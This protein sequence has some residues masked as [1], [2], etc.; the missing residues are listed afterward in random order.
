CP[1]I[2]AHNPAV[3]V[4]LRCHPHVTG[5]CAW[6]CK[7]VRKSAR[8]PVVHPVSSY[9]LC[10]PPQFGS[11]AWTA[12]GATGAEHEASPVIDH[13]RIKGAGA[14]EEAVHLETE[15]PTREIAAAW[16]PVASDGEQL[17]LRDDRVQALLSCSSEGLCLRLL[18]VDERRLVVVVGGIE[19]VPADP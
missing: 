3:P 17:D 5:E 4:P 12:Y 7:S 11:P 16:M 15:L 1:D 19:Q 18:L 14:G 2:D 10:D 8:R 9:V 6:S 13:K